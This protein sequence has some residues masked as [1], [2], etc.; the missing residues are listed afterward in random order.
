MVREFQTRIADNN[1]QSNVSAVVSWRRP[2]CFSGADAVEI[3][4]GFLIEK[5]ESLGLKEVTREKAMKVSFSAFL[6]NFCRLNSEIHF[7]FAKFYFETIPLCQR[8]KIKMENDS[9]LRKRLFTISMTYPV[10]LCLGK[11]TCISRFFLKSFR[12]SFIFRTSGDI[13]DK[14][15]LRRFVTPKSCRNVALRSSVC[16]SMSV[17]DVGDLGKRSRIW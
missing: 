9:S 15:N 6:W 4:T 13:D 5:R 11:K 16:S 14:E 7:S 2:K 10:R 8:R 1:S 17:E 3:L 12:D